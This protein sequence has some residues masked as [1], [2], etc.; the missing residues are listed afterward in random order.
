VPLNTMMAPEAIPAMVNNADPKFIF[1]DDAS[2]DLL[3]A[4]RTVL[5]GRADSFHTLQGTVDGLAD[6]RAMIDSSPED[7]PGV[8]VDITDTMS[9]IYSSGTTGTPKGIEHTHRAR[10]A[11]PLG[12]GPA[13]K[14]DRYTVAL[15]STPLYTNGTWITMLPA[16]FSGGT[17]ILGGKF[18]GEAFLDSVERER[19]THAFV[20][21][22]QLIGILAAPNIDSA[23]TSSLEMVLSGG[24]PLTTQTFT[25]VVARF[26]E[27]VLYEVWGLTEGFMTVAVPGDPRCVGKPIYGA[28]L[29]VID[30]DG[31][32]VE[33]GATGEIVGWSA[34]LMKGYYQEPERTAE[35]LW[36]GP[37]GRTYLRSGDVGR[38]DEDGFVHISG[39]VKDMIISGGINIYASDI[40]DV[41]MN[42]P[43]VREVAVVGVPHEKW[44]ETP[45]L[46]AIVHDG[47]TVDAEGLKAW[48]NAKLG[49]YQRVSGVEFRSEFPRATHDKVLKRALRDPYWEATSRQI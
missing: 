26:G 38:I 2:I 23:D 1:V 13:L 46:F 44:G 31:N 37:M 20:V 33:P 10:M 39:R 16:L 21:P 29:R 12:F 4:N 8:Q 49:G 25:D 5:A 32:E 7:D 15:C 6:G 9:I 43:D 22:T 24:A 47:V 35:M 41:F 28:D 19:V 18:S 11:Y 27:H 48:G 40:E 42:H 3:N 30:A 36:A 17:V 14:I 34:A 45:L